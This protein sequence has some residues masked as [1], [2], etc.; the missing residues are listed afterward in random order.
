MRTVLVK[1]QFSAVGMRVLLSFEVQICYC[2]RSI[3]LLHLT[4]R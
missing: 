1:S 2:G 4:D 3:Y